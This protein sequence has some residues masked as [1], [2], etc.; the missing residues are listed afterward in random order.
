MRISLCSTDTDVPQH[1]LNHP[2]VCTMVEQMSRE[3]MSEKLRVHT[4]TDPQS[5]SHN[6]PSHS[7]TTQWPLPNWDVSNRFRD[8]SF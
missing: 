1:F 7:Y 2:Y 3:R 5:D 8:F 6:H 4:D